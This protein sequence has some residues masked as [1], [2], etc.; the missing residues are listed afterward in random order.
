MP[1][2]FMDYIKENN[3]SS[4]DVVKA[5]EEFLAKKE[6]DKKEEPKKEEPKPDEKKEE[7][8]KEPDTKPSEPDKSSIK[9]EQNIQFLTIDDAKTLINEAMIDLLKVKRKEEPE[10]I[11]SEKK[12]REI[13]GR[14]DVFE[15]IV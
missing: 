2:K 15:R 10:T 6:P 14:Q 12:R 13:Q 8:K 1:Y 9:K 3:I 11:T 4:D 7:I 5:L